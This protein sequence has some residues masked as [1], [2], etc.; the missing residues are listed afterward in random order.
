MISSNLSTL[1]IF[2]YCAAK[3][4]KY[5]KCIVKNT[6]RGTLRIQSPAF[7]YCPITIPTTMAATIK[8]EVT[9]MMMSIVRRE[10]LIL[11]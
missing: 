3:L 10:R 1:Q 4:K 9:I 8:I 5:Y 6:K 7:H 2:H 11:S